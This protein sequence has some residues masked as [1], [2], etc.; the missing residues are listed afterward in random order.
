MNPHPF[1]LIFWGGNP[2]IT[3]KT[4]IY[5]PQNIQTYKLY[6]KAPPKKNQKQTKH[7]KLK[8]P[9]Q[10]PKSSH[11]SKNHI[12]QLFKSKY[13]SPLCHSNEA[14]ADHILHPQRPLF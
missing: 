13:S 7:L 11:D 10:I 12:I 5:K 9:H 14:I 2:N 4:Q 3:E 6:Q 8:Q 1:A